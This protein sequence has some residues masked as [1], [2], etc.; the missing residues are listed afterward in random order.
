MRIVNNYTVNFILGGFI[1]LLINSL[2]V[3]SQCS[4]HE[5]SFQKVELLSKFHAEGA[6]LGDVNMDG[7]KDVIAGPYWF[8]GPDFQEKHEFYEPVE[9]NREEEYSDNFIVNLDD[10]NQDGWNDIL[11]IGFPGDPAYWYE[12]PGEQ[13]NYRWDKH[14][15]HEKV[16]NESPT[17]FDLTGN[18]SLELVF[19]TDGVLGYAKSDKN[20]PT[21][22]WDFTPVSEDH[23]WERF[24]HGLGIGDVDGDGFFDLIKND[25]WWKNPGHDSNGQ[26]W[27]YYQENFGPGGAQM[28]AYDVDKDG[29]Q[30]IITTLDAH[31]WGLAWFRQVRN[32]DQIGFEQRTI[33]GDNIMDNPFG[34]R[35]SQ[36]HTLNVADINNDGKKDLITGK[37]VW[38]RGPQEG[39]EPDE[40]AVLYYFQHCIDEES[41]AVTYL[42][43]II[44]SNS[45]VGVQS[46]TKDIDGDGDID[47]LTSNKN[48]TFLFLNNKQ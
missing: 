25:G 37:R 26:N 43:F 44:D 22:A 42:P 15:I 41:G 31:G 17:F 4:I 33:M 8:E 12:N 20:N 14:L 5:Q 46:T 11:M 21:E 19:H 18:G 29:Y 35:F 23:G 2:P 10:V 38:T 6:A 27:N 28:Y 48:G 39:W 13:N 7:I 40:P 24:T 36:P 47:I 3:Y 30:D 32:G 45:G 1:F 9:Y 34:V 16:D